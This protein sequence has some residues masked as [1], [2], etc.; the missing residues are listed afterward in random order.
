MQAT[1]AKETRRT[2]MKKEFQTITLRLTPEQH[3]KLR[4]I[5]FDTRIAISELVR[6]AIEKEY[7]KEEK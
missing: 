7:M 5:S 3:E 1:W 4:Q 2:K 6:V